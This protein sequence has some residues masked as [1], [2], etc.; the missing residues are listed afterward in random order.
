M[1]L[2]PVIVN[3]DGLIKAFTLEVIKKRPYDFKIDCLTTI[4]NLFPNKDPFVV[5]FGNRET[6]VITYKA[7]GIPDS[8]IYIINKKDQI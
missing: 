2:G 4:R 7:V 6:D 5:G 8:G 1:P 3:P